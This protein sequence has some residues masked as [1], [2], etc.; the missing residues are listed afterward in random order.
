[1]IK[2]TVWKGLNP[3]KKTEKFPSSGQSENA[4]TRQE[5]DKETLNILQFNISGISTKK[6]ELAHYL[7]K[8]NIHI[9][10]IQETEKGKDTNLEIS[11]YTPKHCE[12]TNCQGIITYIRNDVTG[13]TENVTTSQPT[14]LQKST[15]WHG[16]KK[17]QVYNLYNPPGNNLDLSLTIIE[18][19]FR[20]TVFAGDYNGHSPSWGYK[21]LDN[22]GKAIEEICNTTNLFLVQDENSQPTLLH[23]VHKT[24]SRPDLTL[25]ST[26]LLHKFKTE[27]T[28][29][30]GNSDH[31]PTITKVEAPTKKNFERR[32][33][34][35]FKK[36]SWNLY[37]TTG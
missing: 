32:T 29:G 17:Y 37:K 4:K 23:R 14:D 21:D 1:M 6:T 35:N 11:G 16:G 27:V 34:W 33:R 3:H 7:D 20:N 5:P 24:L 12:C 25:L 2:V 30:I 15:I 19:D 26:D 22:T 31:R 10:L 18:N 13:T 28:D 36:A 9:A 8:H